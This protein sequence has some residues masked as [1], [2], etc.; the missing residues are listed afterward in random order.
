[1]KSNGYPVRRSAVAR[2]QRIDAPADVMRPFVWVA[3]V[4]FAAG[5]WGYLALAPLFAR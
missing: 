1:M 5:F 2:A 3:A 4:A